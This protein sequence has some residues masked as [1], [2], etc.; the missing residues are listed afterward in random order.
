MDDPIFLTVAE[1]FEN[2][3]VYQNSEEFTKY[4]AAS[5]L[6]EGERVRKFILK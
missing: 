4:W 5:Y 6:E 2:P 1:K 3:I